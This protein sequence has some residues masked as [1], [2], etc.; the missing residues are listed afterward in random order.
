MSYLSTA[1]SLFVHHGRVPLR[2]R[3]WYRAD[4]RLRVRYVLASYSLLSAI[5]SFSVMA[6]LPHMPMEGTASSPSWVMTAQTAPTIEQAPA[7]S[8]SLQ[9]A[10][11]ASVPGAAP[12]STPAVPDMNGPDSP[13]VSAVSS[14]PSDPTPLSDE[15][16]RLTIASGDT[17]S[18]LLTRAGIEQNEAQS[19]LKAMRAHVRPSDLKPGQTLNIEPPKKIADGGSFSRFTLTLDP[20]RSVEVQRTH[21]GFITARMVEKPL[22]NDVAAHTAVIKSSLY[23]AAESAGVPRS[24]TAE[25]IKALGHQIDFQRDLHPGDR[26]EIM[27]DRMITA[28]GHVAKPGRLIFA[29]LYADGRTLN[30]YRYKDSSGREDYFDEKGHSIRKALLRTPLDGARVTSGFGMRRHPL[31]GYS[32]MHKGVDFGASTGTPIYAAGDAV[33]EKATRYGAYG[34]Y[35]RLRHSKTMQ[36]AYAHLSRYASGMR[37]GAKVRQGQIIGYVGTTGRSTG[38]HLH[39][40]LIINGDQVNPQSVKMPTM[41]I[42]DGKDLKKFKETMD[43]LNRSFKDKMN[44][45]RFASGTLANPKDLLVQ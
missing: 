24:V 41:V 8:R 10:D 19:A 13:S 33:V 11:V 16:Q 26:L 22:K 18:G 38:P 4:G 2:D 32:K 25:V 45:V 6:S 20:V 29:R 44:G 7:P 12:T 23:G 9:V 3:Y 31:L 42:L 43:R 21:M 5:A 36:T 39:Y 17:L 40:E 37:P 28:E 35:I 30:I 14:L 15:P 1:I 27:Y 34:N